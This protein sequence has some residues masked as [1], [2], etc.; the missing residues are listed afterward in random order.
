MKPRCLILLLLAFGPLSFAQVM[1]NEV[2]YDNP[3]T[4]NPNVLFTELWGPPGTA[5]GGY[6]LVG[7][8]GAGGG[9]QVVPMGCQ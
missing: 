2:F 6:R 9:S 1:L 5:I 7:I 8:N 4:D 3:G